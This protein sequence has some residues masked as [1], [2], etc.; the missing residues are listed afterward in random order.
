MED[1]HCS[2]RWFK[3]N[4]SNSVRLVCDQLRSERMQSQI[5]GTCRVVNVVD[6]SVND[7]AIPFF[8]YVDAQ[9]NRNRYQLALVRDDCVDDD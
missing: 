7:F 9:R 1:L 4:S 3:S 2:I 8:R 6:A 5:V